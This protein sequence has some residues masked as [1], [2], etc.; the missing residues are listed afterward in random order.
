MAEHGRALEALGESR[1][2]EI[3]RRQPELG[4]VWAHSFGVFANGLQALD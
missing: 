4:M 2:R 3:G 1:G